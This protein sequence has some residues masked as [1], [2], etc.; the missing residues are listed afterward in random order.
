MVD[1]GRLVVGGALGC[2]GF[3]FGGFCSGGNFGLSDSLGFYDDFGGR[4]RGYAF[5]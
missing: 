3:W 2:D 4:L 5:Y 1:G